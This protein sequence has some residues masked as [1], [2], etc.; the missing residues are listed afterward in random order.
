MSA[1][2]T[3]LSPPW[4]RSPAAHPP[5]T[6]PCCTPG[7]P[8]CRAS[9]AA[10]PLSLDSVRAAAAAAILGAP[11]VLAAHYDGWVHFT[12]NRDDLARAFD[13]AGLAARLHAPEH[14]TWV[15]LRH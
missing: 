3:P 6:R 4:P 5:S 1:A 10:G 13:D 14:G 9:S 2:T 11:V 15:P 8:G 12:E 7:R